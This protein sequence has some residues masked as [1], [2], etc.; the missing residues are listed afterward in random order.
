MLRQTPC[1]TIDIVI[2][3]TALIVIVARLSNSAIRRAD[4]VQRSTAGKHE[5]RSLAQGQFTCRRTI[6]VPE[7]HIKRTYS[8]VVER[9][10]QQ[11]STTTIRTN[12]NTNI[13]I[14]INIKPT[15][16]NSSY[17]KIG[18]TSRSSSASSLDRK[19]SSSSANVSSPSVSSCHCPP[20]NKKKRQK[21]PH[22][23]LLMA[24]RP[25]ALDQVS[26]HV[27]TCLASLVCHTIE[28]QNAGEKKN[29]PPAAHDEPA[30][31]KDDDQHGSQHQR[32][33]RRRDQHA[34]RRYP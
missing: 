14:N 17:A 8:D 5:R 15:S 19:Y 24:E 23:I 16:T 3:L 21:N 27:V 28:K 31:D 20:N 2:P 7:Q 29:A 12:I 10:N 33:K 9:R 1:R 30:N 6:R 4:D 22:V 13:N 32:Y 26:T 18:G 25:L 11:H 34:I